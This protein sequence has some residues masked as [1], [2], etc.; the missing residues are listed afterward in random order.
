MDTKLKADINSYKEQI[1]Y[2]K[3][4]IN[5]FKSRIRDIRIVDRKIRV[6]K[7]AENEQKAYT[8]S[9][10]TRRNIHRTDNER[11]TGSK[12]HGRMDQKRRA[13]RNKSA[14]RH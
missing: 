12:R 11:P 3:S 4:C 6:I 5:S 1:D 7:E 13:A 9:I 14:L 8:N 2:H 10:L